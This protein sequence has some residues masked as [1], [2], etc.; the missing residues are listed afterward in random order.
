MQALKTLASFISRRSSAIIA[1]C[2]YT[3]WAMH[4]ESAAADARTLPAGSPK[5]QLAETEATLPRTM[6]AF[7]GAV[8]EKYPGYLENCQGFVN[9]LVATRGDG[10]GID[11][12]EANESS[13]LGAAVALACI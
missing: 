8:I 3:L 2:V 11:L 5:A 6:V 1:T 9:Q 10:R 12:V 4:N 7:N 13:L